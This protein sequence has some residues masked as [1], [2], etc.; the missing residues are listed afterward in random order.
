MILGF[1]A[2]GSRGKIPE[3]ER[4]SML[5]A[6]WMNRIRIRIHVPNLYS[7]TCKRGVPA[8]VHG[9]EEEEAAVEDAIRSNRS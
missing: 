6:E 7:L 3:E 9:S 4:Q 8:L 1:K 5:C 2:K